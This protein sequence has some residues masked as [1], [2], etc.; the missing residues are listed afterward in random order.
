MSPESVPGIRNPCWYDSNTGRWISEDPKG[1]AAGQTNLYVYCGN[2]PANVTDP[3]GL[4][5]FPKGKPRAF[6]T[7]NDYLYLPNGVFNL[8]GYVEYMQLVA[9]E[10]ARRNYDYKQAAGVA[11]MEVFI[12]GTIGAG[13]AGA[14]TGTLIQT[15]IALTEGPAL[16]G[17]GVAATSAK[18]LST[19]TKYGSSKRR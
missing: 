1:F 9:L 16:T 11:A 6:W 14:G 7:L 5:V 15:P 19:K 3:I 10:N 8:E 18:V 13:M 17:P 4:E 2:S 12:I